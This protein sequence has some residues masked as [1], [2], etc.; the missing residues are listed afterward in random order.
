MMKTE[1]MKVKKNK[2]KQELLP[3]LTFFDCHLIVL[4]SF[5]TM[6]ST[7]TRAKSISDSFMKENKSALNKLPKS[8]HTRRG[9]YWLASQ[10][11]HFHFEL[12]NKQT[13]NKDHVKIIFSFISVNSFT[14]TFCRLEFWFGETS[15]SSTVG[16]LNF[17]FLEV[18]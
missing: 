7:E 3:V 9:N 16:S 14:G 8:S 15:I 1:Y 17:V 18:F 4:W 2:T 6:A 11:E 12:K 10:E 13:K 5:Y